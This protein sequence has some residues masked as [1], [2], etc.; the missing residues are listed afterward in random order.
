[1]SSKNELRPYQTLEL[2]TTILPISSFLQILQFCY[3]NKRE[4]N[5]HEGTTAEP[6]KSNMLTFQQH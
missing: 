2:T 1:M 6:K 4:I 5:W 3:K